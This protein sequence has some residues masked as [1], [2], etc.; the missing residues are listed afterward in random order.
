MSEDPKETTPPIA[1]EGGTVPEGGQLGAPSVAQRLA[2]WQRAGGIAT[3]L[4]TA[5]LAF[6]IGGLVILATTGK[7]PLSTYAGIFKGTGLNWLFP[8]ET[9]DEQRLQ[10]LKN[11]FAMLLLS[12]GTPMW[13]MGD[14]FARTQD[15][16]ENP[17]NIDGPLS[18][19]DW[20]RA[21][22]WREL[23][24]FVSELIELRR[25]HPP[26]GFRFYGASGEV[27][28]SHESRSIAWCASDLY[29]MVNVW[30]EPVTFT[31]HEPGNWATA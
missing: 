7:N 22:E 8:W 30:W 26:S 19:V 31:V 23:T 18:W 17:Y 29:V 2:L 27:D 28:E 25:S 4:M 1:S 9:G 10:Q 16:H 24:E 13:V 11:Y 15:G 3:P 20:E 5:V 21:N 12:A 14:E 6:F